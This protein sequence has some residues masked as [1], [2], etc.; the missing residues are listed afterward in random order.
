VS[1]RIINLALRMLRSPA[2]DPEQYIK[3]L[4]AAAFGIDL[5]WL[6]HVDGSLSLA[7]LVKKHHPDTPVILGGLSATYYHEE[8]AGLSFVDFIVCGESTKSRS[9]AHGRTGGRKRAC[10]TSWEEGRRP[11]RGE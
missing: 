11:H 7:E 9:A 2:F 6:P 5:H 10:P 4:N 8:T 1:V 3:T